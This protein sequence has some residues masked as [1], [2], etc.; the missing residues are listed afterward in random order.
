M[1][2]TLLL[3]S[4]IC[5]PVN[6]FALAIPGTKGM[7]QAPT[8]TYGNVLFVPLTSF[9]KAYG[10]EENWN[11][12]TKIVTLE[13]QKSKYSF[14]AGSSYALINGRIA[15][16]PANAK[17]VNGRLLIPFQFGMQ[18]MA[19]HKDSLIPKNNAKII[20]KPKWTPPRPRGNFTIVLDPGHGGKDVGARGKR[21]VNEKDINLD[22][23]KR[24]R[25]KLQAKGVNVVMTRSK[26]VFIEL[27]RRVSI[28]SNYKASLF[29]SIHTNAARNRSVN[30]I[31]V[32]YFAGASA[33]LNGPYY[34]QNQNQSYQYARLAQAQMRKDVKSASRG[35][36]NARYYVLKNARTPAVLI[37][38]G[39]ITNS[40]EEGNLVS[41][42]HREKL[43]QAITQSI[44]DYKGKN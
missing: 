41:P 19:L 29:V 8:F 34:R 14:R 42:Y 11:S 18:V 5:L 7:V 37:E 16:M 31:E 12:K 4:L 24:V 6:L 21:G 32:F 10:F 39:F 20:P 38:V 17:M 33:K 27:W 40:W 26:D 23:A 25:D 15:R 44:V 2:R 3:I 9:A 13:A 35:V 22:I 43:A 36:K 30:G 28:A 1:R